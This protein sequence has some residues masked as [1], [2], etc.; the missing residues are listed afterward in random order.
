MKLRFHTRLSYGIGGAADEAIY[1]LVS[2]Y[3]MFFLT[4]IADIKPATAGTIAAVGPLWDAVCGPVI[5]FLSDNTDTRYGKRKPFLLISAVPAMII[6]AL[7]FTRFDLSYNLRVL[8]HLIATLLLWQI[9]S[10][11]FV[12][13]IAWGSELTDDY[14][15]RT[16]LRSYAYIGNMA[17]MAL[18]MVA[19]NVLTS[20]LQSHGI[21][22]PLSWS[23]TALMIG[24]VVCAVLLYTA[25]TIKTSDIRDWKKPAGPKRL[26]TL[27]RLRLMFREYLEILNL[28]PARSAIGASIFFLIANTF[29]SASIIYALTYRLGFSAG[30]SSIALFVIMAAGVAMAPFLSRFAGM[31]DKTLA[32]RCGMAL[33]GALLLA[34]AFLKVDSLAGCLILCVIYALGNTCYWQ[35]M[36]SIIYDVCEVEELASGAP[37]Y[38]Q[39]ISMQ[40]LCE[41]CANAVGA[42]LLGLVLSFSG[43][44]GA[45]DAQ[46]PMALRWIGY[47]V[48]LIPGLFFLISALVFLR[49]PIN[50]NAYARVLRALAA[51]SA[52]KSVDM[53]EFRDIYGESLRGVKIK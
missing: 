16:V 10:T 17:G 45:L 13:Y 22:K 33:S 7:T 11:F 36:P 40:A 21:S 20:L 52:G 18:G 41:S 29:F 3:L 26:F 14:H 6:T 48:T 37:H 46:G 15:E 49:H 27:R 44:D 4:S 2:T 43:F 38:G 9:F 51:R 19:P 1:T 12:P 8:Y 28:R 47:S 5:G 31:T 53:T 39:V 42:Q 23:L 24:A 35:L 30:K 25:L 50:K 34:A 32:F